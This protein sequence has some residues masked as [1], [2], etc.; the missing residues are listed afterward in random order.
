MAWT[1]D[2]ERTLWFLIHTSHLRDAPCSHITARRWGAQVGQRFCFGGPSFRKCHIQ[3]FLVKLGVCR[4]LTVG[5]PSPRWSSPMPLLFLPHF[6]LLENTYFSHRRL[7]WLRAISLM[8]SYTYW[9]ELK[10]GLAVAFMPL[11]HRTLATAWA[12][13]DPCP[14]PPY[15]KQQTL[16]FFVRL[17]KINVLWNRFCY[18]NKLCSYFSINSLI[19]NK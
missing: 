11:V 14:T 16:F 15:T 6:R 10:S 18:H 9:Q 1:E 19:T 8:Y 2:M 5:A 7:A 3:P 4:L 17:G 13:T 12:S